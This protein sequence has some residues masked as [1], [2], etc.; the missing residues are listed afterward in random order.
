MKY[1]MMIALLVF[2]KPCTGQEVESVT[3]FR[4][5][6]PARRNGEP[7][8]FYQL[9]QQ[10]ARQLGIDSLQNGYDSL[11]IRIWY[12]PALRTARKLLVLK[13][14]DATW[15]AT[16]YTM[17][18][19]W[20]GVAETVKSKTVETLSPKQGWESFLGQLF[21]LQILTLPHMHD[22]PG[23]RDGFT[24]G[25]SYNVEVATKDHYRF[26]GYHLP[27][28]FQDKYVQ[29][30]NMVDILKLMDAAFGKLSWLD[31]KK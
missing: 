19:D 29:A 26:Y 5:E 4:R 15:S 7:D 23:L 9:A 13:K 6:I 10:K 17:T 28:Y 27:E 1:L 24:D 12:D 22:I 2:L 20:D 30:R 31:K 18:V 11:Q 21:S 25:Y 8:L 14:A 16:L 3:P